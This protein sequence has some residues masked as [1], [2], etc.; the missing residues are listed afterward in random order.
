[1]TDCPTGVA[2]QKHRL[3]MSRL[4]IQGVARSDGVVEFESIAGP[5]VRDIVASCPPPRGGQ[6]FTLS[7]PRRGG[8]ARSDEVVAFEAP[9]DDTSA[10]L[11]R[12]VLLNEMGREGRILQ[13]T[14]RLSCIVT[15]LTTRGGRE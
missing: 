4:D 1:G 6:V 13:N 9:Q 14:A 12:P 10:S 8:V 5:P 7:P 2:S 3:C 15:Q 11:S